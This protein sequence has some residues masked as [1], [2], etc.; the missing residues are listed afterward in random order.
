[1][2]CQDVKTQDTNSASLQRGNGVWPTHKLTHQ[3][4]KCLQVQFRFKKIHPEYNLFIIETAN[5]E[6][7]EVEPS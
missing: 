4:F 6:K 1:M 5:A 2:G 3:P 7:Q